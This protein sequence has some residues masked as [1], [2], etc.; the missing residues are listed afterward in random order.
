MDSFTH[1]VKARALTAALD[2]NPVKYRNIGRYIGFRM[3][4]PS[5]EFG[6]VRRLESESQNINLE[7]DDVGSLRKM[8][9]FM[10]TGT[11]EDEQTAL[12]AS[13]LETQVEDSSSIH[14]LG[15]ENTSE[16]RS[17]VLWS[18]VGVY[19]LADKYDVQPLKILARQRFQDWV[20]LNWQHHELPALAREVF[21]TTPSSDLGLR[22]EIAKT[23]AE[24]CTALLPQEDWAHTLEE[25][26]QMS[27][28]VA[29]K[30]SS[31]LERY[32]AEP[33]T[34]S[35][36]RDKM[37]N[38]RQCR[39]CGAAFNACIDALEPESCDA[40]NVGPDI[41]GYSTIQRIWRAP[42]VHHAKIYASMLVHHVL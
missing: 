40:E 22:E 20:R 21:D 6:G 3:H 4:R 9:S 35:S 7:N 14:S 42:V 28:M 15:A 5:K 16:D 36:L 27:Y 38:R 29:V 23:L 2:A 24:H 13:Q 12:S 30:L 26:A 25:N 18:G 33:P 19:A 17:P 39:H 8:L 41:N 10:Y 34:M 32:A 31:K 1:A 37:N 11:Y